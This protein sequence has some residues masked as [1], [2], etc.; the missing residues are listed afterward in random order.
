MKIK[1]TYELK[2]LMEILQNSTLATNDTIMLKH[3]Q[4]AIHSV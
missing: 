1:C 2:I 4:H 3:G